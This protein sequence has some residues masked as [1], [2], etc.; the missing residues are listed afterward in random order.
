MRVV[1]RGVR[2]CLFFKFSFCFAIFKLGWIDWQGAA[3]RIVLPRRSGSPAPIRASLL[4]RAHDVVVDFWKP[5]WA[6]R[7]PSNG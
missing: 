2:V 1:N 3:S 7:A 6:E 4:V 5:P